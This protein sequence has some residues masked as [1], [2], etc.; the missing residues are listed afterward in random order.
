MQGLRG[1]PS[2]A[3]FY[4]PNHES[5]ALAVTVGIV[6]RFIKLARA[7]QQIPVVLVI[8]DEKDLIS[9][10]NTGSL[11]Y[12]PLL[13]A[14]AAREIEGPTVATALLNHVGTRQPCE[15][16]TTCGG[17]AHFNPEGYAELAAIVREF[18]ASQE[19]TA[20]ALAN[21]TRKKIDADG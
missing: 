9:L 3:Q 10:R 19:D 21:A 8:P 15:I 20:R 13:D 6:E 18:L 14:L 7:R 1:V 11:P 12:Q 2:Y 4:D 16:Y 5:A 17:S